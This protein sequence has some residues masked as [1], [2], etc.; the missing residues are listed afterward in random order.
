MR[1]GWAA[2]LSPAC[3]DSLNLSCCALAMLHYHQMPMPHKVEGD[4]KAG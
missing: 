2:I 4:V 1:K 3:L